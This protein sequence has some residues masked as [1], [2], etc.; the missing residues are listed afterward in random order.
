[1]IY[2]RKEGGLIRNGL[3]ICREAKVIVLRF[4]G[5]NLYV[6]YSV[7]QKKIII[8]IQEVG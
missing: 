2:F 3:N 8:S 6:R 1:M 5:R 4:M 7:P